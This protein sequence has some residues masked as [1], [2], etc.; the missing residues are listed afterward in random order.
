MAQ[1]GITR[2]R[3]LYYDEDVAPDIVRVGMWE[4]HLAEQ[5]FGDGCLQKGKLGALLY[6]AWLGAKRSGVLAPDV[7]FESWAET[8]ALVEE[9]E[10]G[11]SQVPPA[12]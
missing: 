4:A 12:T 8:V 2:L 6:I 9:V 3:V 1:S 10:P 7:G 11:E 5:K